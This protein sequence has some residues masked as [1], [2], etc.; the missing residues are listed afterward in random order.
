LKKIALPIV[1]SIIFLACVIL[2]AYIYSSSTATNTNQLHARINGNK[3]ETIFG[4][5]KYDLTQSIHCDAVMN[6]LVGYIIPSNSSRIY[7]SGGQPIFVGGR[8]RLGLEL[9]AKRMEAV[10]FANT[11]KLNPIEFSI[12][13]WIKDAKTFQ[14]YGVVVSHTNQKGTAGWSLDTR[15]SSKRFVSLS[16]FNDRGRAFVSPQAPISN[17]TFTHIV[18]TFDGSFIKIYKN[19]ILLGSTGFEGKYVS[20]P[21]VPLRIGS[22]AFCLTCNWWSGVINNLRFYN[23][24]INENE[25]KEIFLNDSPGVVPNSLV[26]YWTFNGSLNDI[27]GNNNDGI[28]NS[29]IGNM[30]FAPDG[31]LFFTEKNTGKIRV[32]KDNRVLPLPFAT[33]S[34]YYVNWQQG[35]MGLTIDPKFDQNHFIYLYYVSMDNKTGQ[36]QIFNRVV[37]FT[38]NNNQGKDM[39]VLLDK[40]PASMGYNSGGALAFGGDDKLYIGVGD[41]TEPEFAQDPGILT[42]KVLRINRDGTIPTDNPLPNSPVYTIGH[43]NIFGIAF[44][45]KDGIGIIAEDGEYHYDK[46]NLIQRGGNYGFPTLQPPN[47]APELFT[48]NSSIKPLI[49]YWQTVT[50]TQAIYYV[51]DKIPQLKN[52]FLV[53]AFNGDIYA[54]TLDPH[55]KQVIKQEQIALKHYPFEPVTSIAQ[56]PSGDIYYGGYHIYKLTSVDVNNKRQ[57]LFPIEIKSSTSNID[58]KDLQASSIGD[59]KVIDVHTY[60]KKNESGSPADVLQINVPRAIID[61]ISSVTSTFN[62]SGTQPSTTAVNFVI[63]SNSS[64]SYNTISIHSKSGIYYPQLSIKGITTNNVDNVKTNNTMTSENNA[65]I[66]NGTYNTP[67]VSIAKYASEVSTQKPYDPSPLNVVAGTTVKWMNNDSVI[68]TVTERAAMNSY[69]TASSPP[70]F[71]SGI[72]GPGQKFEHT[73]DRPGIV[74]Y[75]CAIHPFMSGEVIVK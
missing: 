47:I 44:D 40:I 54:L 29:M 25:I 27:S 74:N 35:L 6:R 51:G 24:T 33:V 19:G 53:A 38:D 65:A 69:N 32:M 62:K 45:K 36:G 59:E 63:D 71:D 41:A 68:H 4:C 49:S 34:D 66:T 8:D 31:R 46:I 60:A 9:D 55:N 16:I 75:Y 3:N 13:F 72:L 20:D 57:D 15:A 42:G 7:T 48:N 39:V 14:P 21:G 1:A 30:A 23:N 61:D 5:T 28:L 52:K 67:F 12:S 37:R 70:K 64:S 10:E 50:P 26:G 56:S 2:S 58:V 11:F 43:R 22:S 17:D 73:F 18:G